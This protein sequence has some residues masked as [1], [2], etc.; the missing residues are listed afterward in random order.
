MNPEPDELDPALYLSGPVTEIL[1]RHP[2]GITEYSLL[3]KLEET[4]AAAGPFPL[5]TADLTD[6]LSLFETHFL[7]FYTLY[8]LRDSVREK[9][10]SSDAWNDLEIHVTCIRFLRSSEGSAP[11]PDSA[12]IPAADDPL[13][14]YY[15][16]LSN[17]KNTGREDVK[18]LL[19]SFWKRYTGFSR[20][21]EAL[22]YLG[23]PF[24]ASPEDIRQRYRELALKSHPDRGGDSEEFRKLNGHYSDA[25]T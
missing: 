18:E 25:I 14:R 4:A 10:L 22:R 15:L 23:L 7:L 24:D 2:Q 12:G 9:P 11:P 13:R 16:D 17:L 5:H 21:E 1:L 19:Q 6:P 20:K 3:K 8:K